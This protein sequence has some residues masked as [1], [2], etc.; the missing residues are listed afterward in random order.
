MPAASF[1]RAPPPSADPRPDAV[2]LALFFTQTDEA[3]FAALVARHTPA[4]RAV[5][6]TWLRCT[7]DIDDAA[8]ATFLVLVRKADTVR[9]PRKLGAWLCGVAGNVARRLRKQLDRAGPLTADPPGHTPA[10]A[11]HR[12]EALAAEVAILPEKY[13][14][15]VQ[16]HYTAGLSTADIADRLGWPKGT[17][18]TRLDRARKLLERRL[19][20]RGL[21]AAVL[22]AGVGATRPVSAAWTLATARAAAVFKCGEPAASCGVSERSVSLTEGVV[23]AMTW[24]KL[25]LV[26]AVLMVATGVGGFALGQWGTDKADKRKADPIQTAAEKPQPAKADDPKVAKADDPKPA[27]GRRKEAVIKVPTGTFV[28]D[29]DVAAYGSGRIAWTFEEER[30]LG[31]IEANLPVLGGVEYEL[32]TEAE[33]SLSGNGTIYGVVTGVKVTHL[34]IPAELKGSGE[35]AALLPLAEPLLN[36]VLTDLPFSYQFRLVGDRLTILNYRALLAGPNPLGKVGAVVGGGHEFAP[37][38]Y[39]QA[40]GAA[41]EGTYTAGDAEPREQPKKKPVIRKAGK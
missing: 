1:R 41:M 28:K 11:D 21:S 33:Y 22:V 23:R 13:R 38:V 6:G 2:L 34:K 15:P 3:A 4:V 17:V 18:L 37:L 19:V 16:L 12:V 26:L 39:F 31:K 29:I 27:T 5:C 20:A 8:Q 24:N 30:I 32:V 40:F 14:L 10:D 9:D 36:E 7:A 25:R 35:V